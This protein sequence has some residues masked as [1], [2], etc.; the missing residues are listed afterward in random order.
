MPEGDNLT[1]LQNYKL[2]TVHKEI[3]ITKPY[4]SFQ[5]IIG[6]V[7]DIVYSEETGIEFVV[8]QKPCEEGMQ[9]HGVRYS[10]L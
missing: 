4:I 2:E 6:E 8:V 3:L 1:E 5:N 10:S 9:T 7:A